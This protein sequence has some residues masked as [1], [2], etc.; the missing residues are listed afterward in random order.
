MV[1]AQS[2]KSL[3]FEIRDFEPGETSAN[4][5][6]LVEGENE[7]LLASRTVPVWYSAYFNEGEVNISSTD[8]F[9]MSMYKADDLN[10]SVAISE[11][12]DG[13]APD[14]IGSYELNYTV[15][16][17]G[18]YL[19]KLEQTYRAGVVVNVSASIE[20]GID[21][22]GAATGSV[23]AGAHSIVVTP[24][25]SEAFVAIYNMAGQLI[26]AVTIGESTEIPVEKGLYIV[27]VNGQA[28]KVIVHD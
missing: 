8:Y 25:E 1:T 17:A 20:T 3:T 19:I 27:T 16:E 13:T 2:D 7:L 18:L 4:P 28:V 14:Y 22:V 9:L 6:E 24:G 26:K 11:Y 5:I 15:A 12:I 10:T 23:V 21:N